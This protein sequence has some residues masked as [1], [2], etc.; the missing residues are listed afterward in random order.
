MKQVSVYKGKLVYRKYPHVKED[1][2]NIL[3]T[4]MYI[5]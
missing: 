3:Y 4:L 5:I 1:Y 2:R